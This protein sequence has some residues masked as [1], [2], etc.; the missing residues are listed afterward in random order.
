MVWNPAQY[1]KFHGPR[2][3]PALDLLQ[4]STSMVHDVS[5]VR[6]VLDLGCG[7]GNVTPYLCQAFPNAMVDGLD[8]SPEMIE[9][10]NKSKFADDMK[11][12]ISFRVGTIENEVKT[13]ANQYDVIYSNAALHWC[14]DHQ[15]L[16]PQLLQK[17]VSPNGGV[18]AIQMPDTINQASHNLMET[19]GLRSGNMQSIM[20]VRIPRTDHTAEWY[21]RLLS[22]LC[23]EIDIWST[24]Y[25]QQ[26]PASP[27][28]YADRHD[29]QIQRHPVLEYTKAT[30]L[31]PLLQ[32]LG[33]ENTDRCQEFLNEYDRLLEEHYP[34]VV[35][36][37]KYH[38][39]GKLVVL[40]P[41]KR[42]FLVCKT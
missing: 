32:A 17:M 11:K 37:N 26:L 16:F 33:G 19:A 12:R 18:L 38:A 7:P 5:A 40:M 36:K 6:S 21:F 8:F 42:F 35:V 14:E 30:G 4:A 39:N 27:K 22:P 10:A 23:R 24:E 28:S 1:L 3:R 13:N 15:N 25:M 34:T 41:F 2:L 31:Q 20:N 29:Y 9:K